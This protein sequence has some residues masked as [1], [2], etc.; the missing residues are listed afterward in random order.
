MSGGQEV[1]NVRQ[2]CENK[3]EEYEMIKNAIGCKTEERKK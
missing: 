3:G 2:L 1:R